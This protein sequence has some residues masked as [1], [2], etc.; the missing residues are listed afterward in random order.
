[1]N[2]HQITDQVK[3]LS[4]IYGPYSSP[5]EAAGVIHEEFLE[6]MEAIHAKDWE[7]ARAEAFDIAATALKFSGEI[8]AREDRMEG[9][10]K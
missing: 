10:Y 5:H 4:D 6:M 3:K 7:K 9:K 1:M 8:T 2:T